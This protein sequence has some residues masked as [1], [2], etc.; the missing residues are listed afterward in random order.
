VVRW[1]VVAVESVREQHAL[2]GALL[3][4]EVRRVAIERV[5][6]DVLGVIV[7]A[8]AVD[9]LLELNSGERAVELA[10]AGHAVEV[11]PLGHRG[12]IAERGQRV[13]ERLLD[14]APDLELERL[15]SHEG[16]P[17]FESTGNRSV[18]RCP[19]GSRSFPYSR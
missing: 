1:E 9:D 13:R 15:G 11:L 17:L 14:R 19:G 6:Q 5:E 2:A 16:V 4:R 8:R 3:Q 10:P 18:S 12:E 7:Y